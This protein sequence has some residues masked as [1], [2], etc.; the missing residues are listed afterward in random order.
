M[1]VRQES[2]NCVTLPDAES[3]ERTSR[4]VRPREQ[5]SV[6][7]PRVDIDD[8]SALRERDC[9]FTQSIDDELAAHVGDVATDTRTIHSCGL[10]EAAND[11]HIRTG[12]RRGAKR[13]KQPKQPKRAK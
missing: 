8:G 3:R 6:G 2:K 9:S 11:A 7:K 1:N 13:A 12:E 5:L 10:T 4:T